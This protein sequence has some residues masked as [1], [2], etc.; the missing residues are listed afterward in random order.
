MKKFMLVLTLAGMLSSCTY[1]TYTM[2]QD[3]QPKDEVKQVDHEEDYSSI[4]EKR[5]RLIQICTKEKDSPCFFTQQNGVDHFILIYP[6]EKEMF[7]SKEATIN[8]AAAFCSSSTKLSIPAQF[9]VAL[10][11]E[12]IAHDFNC[13]TATWGEWYSTEKQKNNH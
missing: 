7:S 6:N 5:D 10:D 1:N 3:D 11:Y 2:K 9:H 4:K 12:R 8:V 13:S